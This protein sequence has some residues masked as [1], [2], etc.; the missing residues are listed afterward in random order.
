MNQLE[1]AKNKIIVEN[2]QLKQENRRLNEGWS[3]MEDEIVAL[4]REVEYLKM[5]GSGQNSSSADFTCMHCGKTQIKD[6]NIIAS[7]GNQST[8]NSSGSYDS[9][10]SSPLLTRCS[11]K[12]GSNKGF[13]FF[14]F[15][16]A[17]II[18]GVF[19]INFYGGSTQNGLVPSFELPR[20]QT[21]F[22][23]QDTIKNSQD[24]KEI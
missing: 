17:A 13:Y 10:L 4:K 21:N 5:N 7:F 6:E 14:M 9:P 23:L 1:D 11:P 19:T 15:A 3:K 8:E 12:G 18:M 16:F 24:E 2:K 22:L 20:F